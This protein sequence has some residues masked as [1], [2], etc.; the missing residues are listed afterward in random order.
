ME[1]GPPNLISM[2]GRQG[3]S[4]ERVLVQSLLKRLVPGYE[5]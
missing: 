3:W 1:K 2:I 5:N 4:L